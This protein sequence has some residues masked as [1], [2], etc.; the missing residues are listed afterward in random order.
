MAPSINTS[1]LSN[2]SEN[3]IDVNY[4]FCDNNIEC[5]SLIQWQHLH[6]DPYFISNFEITDFDFFNPSFILNTAKL[7]WIIG[8]NFYS[9]IYW[10]TVYCNCLGHFC[11]NFYNELILMFLPIF[12]NIIDTTH[13]IYTVVMNSLFPDSFPPLPGSTPLPRKTLLLFL[14]HTVLVGR[15]FSLCISLVL[16]LYK[17]F[18]F[19]VLKYRPH[20]TVKYL[21]LY[22]RKQRKFWRATL[23]LG[24]TKK[25]IKIYNSYMAFRILIIKK[26]LL[27][28]VQIIKNIC[29][30]SVLILII[31][32]HPA[33]S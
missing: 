19:I 7:A 15:V 2:K 27:A 32:T 14:I 24:D 4:F 18:S 12:N 30:T 6:S 26:T 13:I 16:Y 10:S 21:F 20:F 33:W 22:N 23:S 5:L 1:P 28:I 29:I 3:L 25:D 8:S 9:F 11:N 17:I 31:R